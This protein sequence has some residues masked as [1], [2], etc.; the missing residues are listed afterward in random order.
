MKE[1]K[2]VCFQQM[3]N[4][5]LWSLLFFLSEKLPLSQKLCYFTLTHK[6]WQIFSIH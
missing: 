1:E 5:R 4:K 2:F 3:P 6:M